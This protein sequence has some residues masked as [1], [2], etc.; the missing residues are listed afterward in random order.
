VL[1][2]FY[3]LHFFASQNFWKSFSNP[4]LPQGTF[5]RENCERPIR[6]PF[7]FHT[8][9]QSSFRTHLFAKLFIPIELVRI[10]NTVL[11]EYW[12]QYLALLAQKLLSYG[13]FKICWASFWLRSATALGAIWVN[14]FLK[15]GS[16]RPKTIH[17]DRPESGCRTH[18]QSTK[19]TCSFELRT[20]VEIGYQSYACNCIQYAS[21]TVTSNDVSLLLAIAVPAAL[22]LLSVV[23]ILVFCRTRQISAKRRMQATISS[24]KFETGQRWPQFNSGPVFAAN[25][26]AI[27][28]RWD[29]ELLYL[30]SVVKSVTGTL[31][32]VIQQTRFRCMWSRRAC[33][34]QKRV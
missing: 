31:R 9:P 32:C 7:S 5:Y 24:R 27:R 4:L 13:Y 33:Q 10:I 22:V 14:F 23:I 15:V 26:L 2:N 11:T 25:R 16:Y 30:A 12:C 20:Q 1:Q 19:W 28:L 34:H 8:L 6:A 3:T 21:S 29:E 17:S 18:P